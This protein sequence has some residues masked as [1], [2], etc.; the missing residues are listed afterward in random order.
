M[1]LNDIADK[2]NRDRGIKSFFMHE[3]RD[4]YG[5]MRLGSNIVAEISEELS[6][7]GLG[8]WP[9]HLP[10]D[11]WAKVRIYAKASAYSQLIN[12]LTK[13]ESDDDEKL[14]DMTV[15]DARETLKSIRKLV[16]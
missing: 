11:Q 15:D 3:I 6:A 8:H 2:V 10:N 5:A 16:C 13:F 12:L 9:K 4:A 7:L 14:R 1:P